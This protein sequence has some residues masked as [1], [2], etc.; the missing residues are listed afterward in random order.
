MASTGR[1]A[2]TPS[3]SVVSVASVFIS[4]HCLGVTWSSDLSTEIKLRFINASESNYSFVLDNRSAREITFRGTKNSA[5]IAVPQIAGTL[6]KD[7]AAPGAE[8]QNLPMA[9][10][11]PPE[12]NTIRVP[13][14]SQVRLSLPKN[15][16][17]NRHRGGQCYVQ[18]LLSNRHVIESENF[19]P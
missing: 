17:T 2:T 7:G 9:D 1:L 13:P 8:T 18:L 19:A 16:T 3:S 5:G 14:K 12:H 6:C 4:M 15:E 10:D 11:G